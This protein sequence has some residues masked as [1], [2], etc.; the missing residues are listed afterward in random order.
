PTCP[1]TTVSVPFDTPTQI[2]LD[3]TDRGPAYEQT[4]VLES[5]RDNPAKGTVGD[6]TQGTPA[7][8]TYTPN[9]GFTGPDTFTYIGRDARSF[10]QFGTVTVNVQPKPLDT[11]KPD[12]TLLRV[13]PKKLK[14][15]K[16]SMKLGVTTGRRITFALSEA[17]A[18]TLKFEKRTTGRRVGS[19]CRKTTAANRGKKK[20]TRYVNAGSRKFSAA[21]QGANSIRFQGRLSSTKR[22]ALGKY[23]LT[24]RAK[25]AAGNSEKVKRRTT[26]RL[27]RP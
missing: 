7:T 14:R 23:R 4:E 10:G 12:I 11:T 24:A 5:I 22:L 20:C 26:F 16:A 1:N 9:P 27:V 15:G 25:D 17:A 3:C 8:V 13:R 21:K 18:V 19:T 2:P 6:V